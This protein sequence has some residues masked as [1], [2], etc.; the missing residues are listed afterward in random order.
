MI[1]WAIVA[2]LTGGVH[3]LPQLYAVRLLLGV[4]DAGYGAC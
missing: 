1:S 2:L 4:A 3:T